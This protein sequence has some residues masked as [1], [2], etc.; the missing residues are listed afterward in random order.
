MIFTTKPSPVSGDIFLFLVK[1]KEVLVVAPY[2]QISTFTSFSKKFLCCSL[3]LVNW[4]P[5]LNPSNVAD[6]KRWQQNCNITKMAL[7]QEG[8][9]TAATSIHD[10]VWASDTWWLCWTLS[11]PCWP[12]AWP[13]ACTSAL[14][15]PIH[16]SDVGS[17]LSGWLTLRPSVLLSSVR[18]GALTKTAKGRQFSNL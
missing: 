11:H 18:G 5:W 12:A 1:E 7:L 8:D 10:K 4:W 17:M 13:S 16:R 14:C 2:R 9:P 15:K 6:M 3:W